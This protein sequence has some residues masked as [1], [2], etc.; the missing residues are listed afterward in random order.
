LAFFE[1]NSSKP[2]IQRPL[3]PMQRVQQRYASPALALLTRSRPEENLRFNKL[4]NALL[5][6]RIEKT[7]D[8][9]HHF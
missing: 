9:G 7:H 2:T 8:E 4:F 5:P 6:Y 3:S 1:Q